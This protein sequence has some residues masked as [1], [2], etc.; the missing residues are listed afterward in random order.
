MRPASS[1]DVDWLPVETTTEHH[2][3]C[4]EWDCRHQRRHLSTRNRFDHRSEISDHKP[5]VVFG[6]GVDQDIVRGK[7]AVNNAAV[8]QEGDPTSDLQCCIHGGVLG[9]LADPVQVVEETPGQSFHAKRALFE[10][11]VEGVDDVDMP[12][13]DGLER[14]VLAKKGDREVR[15]AFLEGA[16]LGDDF[17]TAACGGVVVVVEQMYGSERTAANLRWVVLLL[18]VFVVLF[19]LVY[20]ALSLLRHASVSIWACSVNGWAMGCSCWSA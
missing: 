7:V 8:V 17:A 16:L 14:D 6:R 18:V 19:V 11:K 10:I 1:T 12:V 13:A 20:N 5:G 9:K 2:L 3:W 15:T 4:P